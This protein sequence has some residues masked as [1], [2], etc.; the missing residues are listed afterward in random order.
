LQRRHRGGENGDPLKARR[1]VFMSDVPGLLRDPK[2]RREPAQALAGE[3]S[4][5]IA[6]TGVIGEGMIPKVAVRWR[7]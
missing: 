6:K 3:R 5:A 1:L 4:S 7:Q 2:K